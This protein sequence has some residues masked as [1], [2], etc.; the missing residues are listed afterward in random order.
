MNTANNTSGVCEISVQLANSVYFNVLLFIKVFLY[1]IGIIFC[2]V[3]CRAQFRKLAAHTNVHMLLINHYVSIILQ[4]V[5][6]GT[7]HAYDLVRFRLAKGG[8]SCDLVLQFKLCVLFRMVPLA[9]LIVTIFSLGMM[10]VER[11]YAS[12]KFSTY[13]KHT[14][15]LGIC[16]SVVQVSAVNFLRKK[17]Y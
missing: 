7:S 17:A 10:A 13:E 6:M 15:A 11:F 16:L 4:S 8:D 12:L 5:I 2:I 9:C 1:A 14:V 3:L